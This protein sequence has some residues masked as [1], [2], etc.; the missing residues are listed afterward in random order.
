MIYII[1]TE[2]DSAIKIVFT[3][4]KESVNKRLRDL[5]IGNHT[6]LTVIH[7]FNGGRSYEK[8]A[9]GFLHQYN[10]TGEWFD[11]SN[12][13]V[14]RFV[15]T[16]IDTGFTEA[17]RSITGDNEYNCYADIQARTNKRSKSRRQRVLSAL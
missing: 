14:R 8:L 1:K 10:L 12:F 2:D 3:K 7:T 6:K 16:L 11:Y 17:I 13:A 5:Q 4:N 15:N 9:H